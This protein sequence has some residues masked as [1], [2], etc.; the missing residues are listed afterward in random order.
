MTQGSV[1]PTLLSHL[2]VT[3][4]TGALGS[5]KTTVLSH[6]L[7]QPELS[8]TAVI[9]NEF[10]DIGLDHLLVAHSDENV[11]LLES[12]CVCCT[13]R[14]DLAEALGD[15][16][17]RQARGDL[18]P[19]DRIVI[20]TT[21][22]ADP[23]PIAH[24]LLTDVAVSS[25][26]RLQRI[27][28]TVDAVH[29]TRELA[30]REESRR[31]T[32]LAD[33]LLM[34]KADL[35]SSTQMTEA[36]SRVREL[37]A[38]APILEARHGAVEPKILDGGYHDLRAAAAPLQSWLQTDA[39]VLRAH[40]EPHHVHHTESHRGAGIQSFA[41]VREEPVHLPAVLQF[42][43]ELAR[44][45]GDE[46]LRIKGVLHCEGSARPIVVHGIQHLLHPPLQLPAWPSERR[47][48][49]IVFITDGLCRVDIES[50]FQ[51]SIDQRQ[52]R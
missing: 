11:V 33:V 25:R 21:G 15:L 30:T 32:A 20:E 7:R 48:T 34:T 51:Q 39:L 6:L 36:T 49:E 19:F 38:G 42:L 40:N 24:T 16:D 3:I 26:F 37:N 31:Q 41:L 14:S 43:E 4:L 5:G 29:A 35:V 13:L 8:R 18:P 12:G 2:P 22:L 45:H 10:G 52:D 17:S 23:A 28:T 50:R 9:I 44:D 46:L 27:I 47:R 1:V